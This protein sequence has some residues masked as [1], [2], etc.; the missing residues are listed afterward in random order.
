MESDVV[1]VERLE[2]PSR[3][4]ELRTCGLEEPFPWWGRFVRAA[5]ESV[6][7][8]AAHEDRGCSSLGEHLEQHKRAL[9]GILQVVDEQREWLAIEERCRELHQR[10][11]DS[12]AA[13]L[14]IGI[15]GSVAVVEAGQ[16]LAEIVELSRIERVEGGGPFTGPFAHERSDHQSGEIVRSEFLLSLTRD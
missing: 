9:V 4:A 6:V 14:L 2:P 7:R 1:G 3:H 12:L 13:T 11:E 16:D 10:V 5:A 15:D 8:G